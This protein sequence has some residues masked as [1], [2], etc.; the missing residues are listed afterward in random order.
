M[1]QCLSKLIFESSVMPK[2]F[3]ESSV[4]MVVLLKATLVFEEGLEILGGIIKIDDFCVLTVNLFAVV[5]Q[6]TYFV[7]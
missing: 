7:Q 2:C 1:L 3:T 5:H 4:S 6:R